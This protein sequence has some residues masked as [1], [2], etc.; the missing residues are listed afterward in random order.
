MEWINELNRGVKPANIRI[1]ESSENIYRIKSQKS[2]KRT[3]ERRGQN[4][5]SKS[6]KTI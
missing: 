4:D 5:S 3:N 6:S 2:H 1:N